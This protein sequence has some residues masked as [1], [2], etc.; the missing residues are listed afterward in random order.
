MVG[1]RWE[2]ART[3]LTALSGSRN[4]K[5]IDCPSPVRAK[6][7]QIEK[8]RGQSRLVRETDILDGGSSLCGW[9][10]PALNP[11]LNVL[12]TPAS[13][14]L[15]SFPPKTYKIKKEF[16]FIY[17]SHHSTKKKPSIRTAAARIFCC[18]LS[19]LPAHTHAHT[20]LG[21]ISHRVT[22]SA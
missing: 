11:F 14:N 2:G 5:S 8:D 10:F 6:C 17:S 20:H 1:V 9:F 12:A 4:N 21:S 22:S 16:K 3:L 19:N 13:L 7:K 15:A 18:R